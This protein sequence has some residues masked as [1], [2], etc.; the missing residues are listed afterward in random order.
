LYLEQ[1]KNRLERAK[2]F[3]KRTRQESYTKL[4]FAYHPVRMGYHLIKSIGR[5]IQGVFLLLWSIFNKPATTFFQ[6]F[7]G[8]GLEIL[9]LLLNIFNV[10]FIWLP[11]IIRGIIL[12]FILNI[13]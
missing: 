10:V 13:I 2:G 11:D 1:A 4:L 9:A 8:L 12:G 7:G 6:V 3:W 5:I